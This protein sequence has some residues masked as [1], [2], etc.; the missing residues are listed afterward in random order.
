MMIDD[1]AFAD[2]LR[3]RQ[4]ADIAKLA[5]DYGVDGHDRLASYFSV[6]ED[7]G[8]WAPLET[9]DAETIAAAGR[10]VG[11][12]PD[13][14]SGEWRSIA[15]CIIAR[16]PYGVKVDLSNRPEYLGATPA[17]DHATWQRVNEHLGTDA[18]GLTSVVEQLGIMRFGHRPKVGDSFSGSGQISFEAL[19]IGCDS[20]A[21]D[22]NPVAAL[23]TWSSLE[24]AGTSE[25]EIERIM[26]ELYAIERSV[27]ADLAAYE[28]N[29]A[30]DRAKVYLYC[31][32]VRCPETGY[33]I[34]WLRTG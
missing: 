3:R 26:D 9:I 20:Y 2:R 33:A 24:L 4:A 29:A 1:E 16:L 7:D 23:F 14:Q 34:P 13:L 31:L 30:G 18:R 21:S 17:L 10:R 28:T 8:G 32:E 6:R 5:L 11:W 22:Q 19:R 27:E 12:R 15:R 25:D